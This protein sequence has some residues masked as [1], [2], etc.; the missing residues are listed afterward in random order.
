MILT[1]KITV[2]GN[3]YKIYHLYKFDDIYN[4]FYN[5]NVVRT[6]PVNEG[7][8]L[9]RHKLKKER[10]IRKLTMKELSFELGVSETT[11]I[12]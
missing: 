12:K 6:V 4:I 3:G 8:K 7:W 2:Y 11:I 10:T 5:L 9:K 1:C